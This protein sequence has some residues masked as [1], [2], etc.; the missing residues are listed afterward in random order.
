M[1]FNDKCYQDLLSTAFEWID[2]Q[3]SNVLFLYD[4]GLSLRYVSNSAT[5]MYGTNKSDL[6]GK[7]IDHFVHS[8]DKERL[9]QELE[10]IDLNQK[11]TGIFRAIRSNGEVGHYQMTMGKIHHD[12]T[13]E[14]F[15]IFISED[16]THLKK[17]EEMLVQSEKLSSAG[18][19]AAGV[20]HEIRNPLTSLKGFLQLMES[21]VDG[22]GVYL[23][24]MKEEI[25]KIEAIS[26]ELL[27]IAK[28]ST[29]IFQLEDLISLVNE[30]CILMNSQ[31]RMK[32]IE[33]V[34]NFDTDRYMLYCDRSQIKQV[35]INLIKNAIEAMKDSGKIE[36]HI[37][38]KNKL[39]IEIQDEG[40]GIPDEL[41][42]KLGEPF[43][44]TKQTGTG[45][46]LVVT[47]QLLNN[48]SAKLEVLDRQTGGSN[49]R[50]TFD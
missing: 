41:K 30:V 17:S 3:T 26:T 40:P 42:N 43:F 11:R 48:H 28:P 5:R 46:G 4:E 27:F 47:N 31:A 45:L 34:K 49:F 12:L 8:E 38:T 6:I 10:A 16:I 33:L 29:N 44:T 14:F 25:E 15:Y 22:D 37:H 32:D 19:L 7:P 23:K 36:I 21:G 18:Q 24:I 50:I 35:L 39:I 20:A 2:E 13:D 1:M 9:L